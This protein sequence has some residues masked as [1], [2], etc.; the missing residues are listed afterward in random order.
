MCITIEP[1]YTILRKDS[2][3]GEIRASAQD[4][5]FVFFEK[6]NSPKKG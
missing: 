4:Y 3:R 2:E 6:Q 1:L 5:F